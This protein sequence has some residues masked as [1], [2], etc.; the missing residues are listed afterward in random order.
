MREGAANSSVPIPEMLPAVPE[1][2][3]PVSI[4]EYP[5]EEPSQISEVLEE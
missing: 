1:D 2:P 5:L 3:E 4:P